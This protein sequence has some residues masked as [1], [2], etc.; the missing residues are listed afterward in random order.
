MRYNRDDWTRDCWRKAHRLHPQRIGQKATHWSWGE[1]YSDTRWYWYKGLYEVLTILGQ[2][3]PDY[4][5]KSLGATTSQ[6]PD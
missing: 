3:E 6:R 4:I 5:L 1:G 2:E